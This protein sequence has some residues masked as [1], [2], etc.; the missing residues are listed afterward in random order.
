MSDRGSCTVDQLALAILLTSGRYDRHLRHMRSVYAARRQALV[1]AFG[2]HLPRIRLTGLAAGFHAIAPLPPG[3]DEAAVT[4][5]ARE[6]R[7]GLYG[8]SGYRG[9]AGPAGPP[10][11]VVGFGNV[12]ER[13]IDPAI[14]AVADLLS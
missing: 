12:S 9:V 11:L 14:A 3:A 6:R 13:A 8:L 1:N 2:Q 5:A 4:A 7:V 10:A